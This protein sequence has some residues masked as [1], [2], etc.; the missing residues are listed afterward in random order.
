M[1]HAAA[2]IALT[3]GCAVGCAAMIVADGLGWTTRVRLAIKLAASAAFVAVGVIAL[4]SATGGDPG[5][6]AFARAIV[7]G[8]VL[9]AIGDGCLTMRGQR[10]R[11][12]GL[13]AFL[14]GHIAYIAGIAA[15]EPPARWLA[16]AGWLAL[17]PVGVAVIALAAAWRGAGA[18][19]IPAV[20]YGAMLAA[21]VIAALAAAQGAALPEANRWRLVIGATAFFVSDLAVVREWFIARSFTNKLVGLPIYYGGQLWLAWSIAD[22]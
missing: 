9:G 1:D 7:A 11:L 18:L 2:M 10:W 12:A 20:A 15:V 4:A 22:L 16:D 8:L 6:D 14:L 19:R 13:V 3:A 17:A 21:M 5:R